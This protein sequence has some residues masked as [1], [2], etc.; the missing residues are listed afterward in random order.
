MLTCPFLARATVGTS[1]YVSL[2]QFMRFC[3][4][5]SKRP[6]SQL[7]WLD[8]FWGQLGGSSEVKSNRNWIWSNRNR[9]R[10]LAFDFGFGLAENRNLISRFGLGQAEIGFSTEISAETEIKDK[11]SAEISNLLNYQFYLV[12]FDPQHLLLGI[13]GHSKTVLGYS[14]ILQ[15][16]EIY[17]N[18]KMYGH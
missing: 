6:S 8:S 15:R 7:I 17:R 16:L 4:S 13:S 18:L 12:P 1:L 11:F 5:L 10:K 3:F 9:N 2:L 14:M